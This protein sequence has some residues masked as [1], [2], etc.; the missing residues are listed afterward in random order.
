MRTARLPEVLCNS[1]SYDILSEN[2]HCRNFVTEKSQKSK[3][4]S[5]NL[6]RYLKS[7]QLKNIVS[8]QR[9]EI[10]SILNQIATKIFFK[11][12]KHFK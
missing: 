7:L 11:K 9:N 1:K 2:A 12:R 6:P 10:K 5:H 4:H 8:F 3:D